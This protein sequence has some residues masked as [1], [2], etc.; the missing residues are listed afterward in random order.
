MA[1]LLLNVLTPEGLAFEGEASYVS[2]PSK[3]GV[4]GLMPGYTPLISPL[5]DKGVLKIILPNNEER[6]FAISF[7]AVEVKKEKTIILTEKAFPAESE[8]KAKKL[9]KELPFAFAQ[10]ND[11]DIKTASYKIRKTLKEGQS[12]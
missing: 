10:D 5:A 6:F 4:L 12:S 8:E 2:L 9:L 7:G 1:S 3:K 11:R